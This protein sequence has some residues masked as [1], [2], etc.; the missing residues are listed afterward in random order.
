MAVAQETCNP[1]S[2]LT[3]TQSIARIFQAE[4]NNLYFCSLPNQDDP[5]V[6]VELPSRFRNAIWL[7]RG[8]YVLID[9]K[10]TNS[11]HNKIYGEISNIV[12]DEHIWR[13]QSY[14]PKEFIKSSVF[15]NE[16]D[17]QKPTIGKMPNSDSEDED[18]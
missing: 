3:A 17:G 14:W 13:K 1:P 5:K 15:F 6:L 18:E 2:E 9:S 8:N 4:G 7:K 12:R 16:H 11:R 10:E